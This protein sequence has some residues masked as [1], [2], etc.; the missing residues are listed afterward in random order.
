[1]RPAFGHWEYLHTYHDPTLT[2]PMQHQPCLK[3]DLRLA[4]SPNVEVPLGHILMTSNALAVIM[5]VVLLASLSL[6]MHVRYMCLA[7]YSVLMS[8]P[9]AHYVIAL[10]GGV[11][12]S[13]I[14]AVCLEHII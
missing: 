8:D 11:W 6:I 5:F 4:V 10:L 7:L 3:M 1:M 9:A 12:L 14:V 2:T 13:Y